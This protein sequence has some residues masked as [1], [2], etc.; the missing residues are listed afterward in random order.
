MTDCKISQKSF[1][2]STGG[3]EVHAIVTPSASGLFESQLLQ[4]ESGIRSLI[5]DGLHAI[6]VRW[7]LT[8]ASNQAQQVRAVSS[9]WPTSIVEQPPLNGYKVSAWVWLAE[10]N[11]PKKDA[12]G[13]WAFEHGS[14]KSLVQTAACEPGLQSATATRAFLGDL[15]LKLDKEGGSLKDNCL[16]TWLFVRDVDVNYAGVV[17]GRNELFALNDLTPDTHFIASTGI[18]G[19]HEDHT[20]SVQMDSINT[21][22]LSA[23]QTRFLEAREYLNPTS[24]YGVAFERGT[25]VDYGDRRHVYISGTASIN[26][27][28]EVVHVGDIAGQTERMLENISALLAEA[29]CTF[30]DVCHML[31][32]I[33]D[34]ADK[35]L[36]EQI[37]AERFPDIPLVI[38]L[39]PVC[40]PAWL[41]ETECM[42]FKAIDSK[43]ADF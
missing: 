21:L 28:G 7:F 36:V 42:A 17:A 22:G 8:D 35:A 33:R 20:V 43:H 31:I 16:R 5:K 6:M 15:A 3:R 25:S 34:I 26:N 4:V 2:S 27:R 39:A 38:L 13:F 29:D 40:R 32:Y 23:G 1:V 10:I 24:E 11:Q 12:D 19:A 41:I 37:F 9:E 14:Y 30:N 18:C